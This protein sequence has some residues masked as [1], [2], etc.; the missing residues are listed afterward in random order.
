[1]PPLEIFC[2]TT[3]FLA[4]NHGSHGAINHFV[5]VHL[6]LP[7]IFTTNWADLIRFRNSTILP[8]FLPTILLC[9]SCRKYAHKQQLCNR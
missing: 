1:L 7:D 5:L 9:R 2:L 8:S 3:K 6:L 4:Q